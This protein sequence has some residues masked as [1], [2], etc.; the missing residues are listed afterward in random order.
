MIYFQHVVF[1]AVPGLWRLHMVHH[2]DLD[3]DLTTGVRFHPFEVLLSMVVKMAALGALGAGAVGGDPVRDTLSATSIFNHGNIT[4]PPA[5]DR[6]LRLI[7]VTPDM[8][9]VHHSA[10]ANETTATSVSIFL[11]GPIVRNVPGRSPWRVTRT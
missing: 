10:I 11:V 4:L 7:V 6:L 5:L 8:H 9:R 1:H 3:F 2:A